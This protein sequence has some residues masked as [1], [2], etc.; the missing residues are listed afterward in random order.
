MLGSADSRDASTWAHLLRGL[1]HV[2]RSVQNGRALVLNHAVAEGR[3]R[4]RMARLQTL[5]RTL[6]FIGQKE[7]SAIFFDGPAKTAPE[8]IAQKARRN[9][10]LAI[11]Q[12]SLL[13]EVIIG[14]HI[15][16]PVVL[17]SRSVPIVSAAL[18]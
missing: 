6:P 7:E 2:S 4:N 17:I 5:P 12:F 3:A 11:L 1:D 18:G 16:R 14:H 9:V 10:G 13:V 8:R 15:C